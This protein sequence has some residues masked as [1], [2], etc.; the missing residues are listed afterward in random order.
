MCPSEHIVNTMAVEG[1]LEEMVVQRLGRRGECI[2]LRKQQMRHILLIRPVQ[3]MKRWGIYVAQGSR[4][5]RK[6]CLHSLN[7][8]ILY[9]K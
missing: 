4:K 5:V 2:L 7:H 9:L 6:T 8:R 1:F 3:L